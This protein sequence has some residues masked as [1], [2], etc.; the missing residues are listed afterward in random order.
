MSNFYLASKNAFERLGN[1]P[2]IPNSPYTKD[3]VG[4]HLNYEED[5]SLPSGQVLVSEY[6]LNYLDGARKF[7]ENG[8]AIA[9][10]FFESL[11]QSSRSSKRGFQGF[12]M[13]DRLKAVRNPLEY[14]ETYSAMRRWLEDFN[15][16]RFRQYYPRTSGPSTRQITDAEQVK[17]ETMNPRE[18]KSYED[19][20]DGIQT[21]S[22]TGLIPPP[23]LEVVVTNASTNTNDRATEVKK[24][25]KVKTIDDLLT[26][27]S[28]SEL[29]RLK[30]Q[31]PETYKHFITTHLPDDPKEALAELDRISG[32][33]E[34]SYRTARENPQMHYYIRPHLKANPGKRKLVVGSSSPTVSVIY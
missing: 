19:E 28:R 10:E 7:F 9:E 22:A 34:L 15:A 14:G 31:Y 27:I 24:V 5:A 13:S 33:N 3:A 26:K 18:M 11:K 29:N 6:D 16:A 21:D 30:S 2:S 23:D 32:S 1:V 4:R 12:K 8:V 25:V 17:Y 20:E